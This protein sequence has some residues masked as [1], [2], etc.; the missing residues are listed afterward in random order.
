MLGYFGTATDVG[1]YAAVFI[2]TQL[3][4]LFGAALGQTLGT[5]IAALHQ[6]SDLLGM[7]SLLAENIRW[8]TLVS[9][10]VFAGIVFWGDRIDLLLGPSFVVDAH[11]VMIVGATQLMFTIFA[12]S[13]YALSM[14]GWHVIETGILAVGLLIS[15][16]M[17]LL[18]VPSYGQVGAALA[19]FTAFS[20]VNV[21][22][23]I[24]VRKLFRIDPVR[25]NVVATILVAVGVA[26]GTYLFFRS[27]D[28]R[29]IFSTMLS[30]SIFVS[31]YL[32]LAWSALLSRGER[33]IILEWIKKTRVERRGD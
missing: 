11:V 27:I 24:I 16:L 21:L 4:S 17:C 12:C 18:L 31:I 13:G 28:L 2:I 10:P 19:S 26:A 29:T 23:Y 15:V 7:E 3:I 32:V 25:L 6:N 33:T 22:R 14:T 8:T 20:G 1:Q 30:G 5:G 9:A